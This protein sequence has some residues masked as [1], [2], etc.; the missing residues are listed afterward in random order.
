MKKTLLYLVLFIAALGLIVPVAS[1][2]WGY[3]NKNVKV[4]TRNL[5]L[6]A[7]IFKVVEAAQVPPSI[8]LYAVPRAVAEVY[9]TMLFTSFESRAEGIADEIARDKPD[10]IGLQEVSTYYIQTPGDYLAGNPVQAETLVID[11]YKVLMKIA[12]IGVQHRHLP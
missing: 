6:G 10:V 5:Y 12:S 11:F 4:M 3:R 2:K 7:D 9:Q 8:D 1:A